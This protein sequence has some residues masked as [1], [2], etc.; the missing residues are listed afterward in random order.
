MQ[1]VSVLEDKYSAYLW[2]YIQRALHVVRVECRRSAV[3][4]V[5]GGRLVKIKMEGEERPLFVTWSHVAAV[6]VC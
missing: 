4:L 6:I 2:L 3:E 1:Q 5:G